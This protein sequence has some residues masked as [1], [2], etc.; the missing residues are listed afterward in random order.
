MTDQTAPFWKHVVTSVTS[1]LSVS[2]LF[3]F[4][5][6]QI[7]G[8]LMYSFKTLLKA[9]H[10]TRSRNNINPIKEIGSHCGLLKK[11]CSSGSQLL[12]IEYRPR[13][14]PDMQDQFP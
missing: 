7:L 10:E 5:Y 12:K 2:T 14:A 9:E 8:L 3:F 4:F 6:S 1:F 11:F 13:L